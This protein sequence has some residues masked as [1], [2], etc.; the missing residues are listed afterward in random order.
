VPKNPKSKNPQVTLAWGYRPRVK[1]WLVSR[2][3]M[4]T[5]VFLDVPE[6]SY[7]LIVIGFSVNQVVAMDDGIKVPAMAFGS[8]IFM[9]CSYGKLNL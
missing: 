3:Q 9:N 8:V 4:I 6:N 7:K 5:D 2:D 1:I